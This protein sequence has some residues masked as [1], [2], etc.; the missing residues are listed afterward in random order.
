MYKPWIHAKNSARKFGGVPEDY[1]PI[2][3]LM[4]SSQRLYRR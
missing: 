4:D 3:N 2:H 1:L